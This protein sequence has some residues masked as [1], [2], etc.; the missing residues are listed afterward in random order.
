MGVSQL[1][2]GDFFKK[3]NSS[4]T[5]EIGDIFY[6]PVAVLDKYKILEVKRSTPEAHTE[7]D[8][9]AVDF[10]DSRHFKDRERL[11][12][13]LINLKEKEE[14]ILTTA[15]KRPCIVLG[16]VN[17]PDI[18]SLAGEERIAKKTFNENI[19]LVAPIFSCSTPKKTTSFTPTLVARI[20]ALYYQQF[21]YLP[22]PI[23]K[24]DSYGSIIRLDYLFPAKLSVGSQKETYKINDDYLMLIQSQ[25]LEVLNI[26]S[27]KYSDYL[28]TVKDAIKDSLPDGL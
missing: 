18:T 5:P 16:V 21:A 14:A 28:S 22:P 17:K 10:D 3:S 27:E 20:K 25:L 11:P 1:F 26:E 8:F 19:Y 12:I 13:K 24:A 7:I 23:D 2:E 9:N 15:K 4:G 6:T